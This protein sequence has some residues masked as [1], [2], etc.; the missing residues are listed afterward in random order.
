WERR[1]GRVGMLGEVMWWEGGKRIGFWKKKFLTGRGDD[2]DVV[3]P[4]ATVWA[5]HCRLTLKLF[6]WHAE[7]LG[8]AN[9]VKVN[10]LRCFTEQQL[11]PDDV[12]TI[13]DHQFRIWY[14]PPPS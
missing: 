2:G 9:G 10:D 1:R 8:S 14:F 4:C 6:R 5:R 11:D 13:A 12:L 7:D 3:P